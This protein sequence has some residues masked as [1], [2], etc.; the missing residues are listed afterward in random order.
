MVSKD[1]TPKML[2][3]YTMY[4]SWTHKCHIQIRMWCACIS[5][6]ILCVTTLPT[7]LEIIVYVHISTCDLSIFGYGRP[8]VQCDHIIGIDIPDGNLSIS[9]SCK[10]SIH[11]QKLAYRMWQVIFDH[12]KSNILPHSSCS[13]HLPFSDMR[14]KLKFLEINRYSTVSGKIKKNGTERI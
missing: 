12:R 3:V 9:N 1:C 11:R 7:G 13:M 5:S 8:I 4:S 6:D 10:I 14:S 2:N